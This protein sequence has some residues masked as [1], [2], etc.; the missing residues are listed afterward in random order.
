MQVFV[1]KID[2]YFFRI[3]ELFTIHTHPLAMPYESGLNIY[4]CRGFNKTLDQ[5]WDE[6]KAFI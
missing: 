1:N 5:V 3:D 4:I 2:K 6:I